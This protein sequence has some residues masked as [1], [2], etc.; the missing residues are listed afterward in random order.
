MCSWGCELIK[1]KVELISVF[2]TK[3]ELK[4]QVQKF[5]TRPCVRAESG[6]LDPFAS[7]I[8]LVTPST[9]L[10]KPSKL[11]SLLWDNDGSIFDIASLNN[12]G[13]TLREASEL[14]IVKQGYLFVKQA[15]DK[16]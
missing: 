9:V 2:V 14:T 11:F 10:E 16:Y 6:T 15:L 1:R 8:D 7:W 12:N 4:S 3:F 5:S 13:Q